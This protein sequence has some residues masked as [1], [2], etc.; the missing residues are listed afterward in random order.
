M[1]KKYFTGNSAH[2]DLNPGFIL[3]TMNL[4]PATYPGFNL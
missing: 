4:N 3:E 1:E 2:P